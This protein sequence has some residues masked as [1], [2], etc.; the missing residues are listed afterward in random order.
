M[1]LQPGTSS[2]AGIAVAEIPHNLPR[3]NTSFVGREHALEECVRLLQT[4]RLL[5]LTG[6]GGSGK[7]RLALRLAEQLLPQYPNGVWFVDLAPLTDGDR[8]PNVVASALGVSEEAGRP[9]RETLVRH[10]AARRALIVLDNCEHVIGECAS[11]AAALLEAADG[12]WIVATSREMLGIHGE[13]T[14]MT[15]SL[16]LARGA[17]EDP[18]RARDSEAVRLFA[19]RARLTHSAFTLDD[20]TAPVV[21]DICQRLDGIPLAIE[22]AA[23][24]V[25]MLSV[26][27]IRAR[28]HDRFRLLAGNRAAA[29]PRHQT[30]RAAMQWSYEHLGEE[31]QRLL[32]GLSIFVGGWT[33]DAA[34]GVCAEGRDEFEVLDLL[35]GLVNK[36]LVLAEQPG[37]DNARY[38][39]LETVREYAQDLQIER[40]ER[41]A[42]RLGHAQ[43]FLTWV[44]HAGRQVTGAEQAQWLDR[45][46]REAGNLRAALDGF[47]S[48][49]HLSEAARVA[50]SMQWLWVIRGY[51]REGRARLEAIAQRA[52]ELE[53]T[54]M[55]AN[56]IQGAGNMCYRLDDFD[57][58]RAHYQRAL[59]MR[60]R[61]GDRAGMAG[62]LGALGNVMQYQGQFAEALQLFSRSIAINRETGNKVWEGANLTCLG[63]CSRAIGDLAASRQY[64]DQALALNREIGHRNGECFSL[65]GLGCVLLQTGDHAGA[66]AAFEQA[67]SIAREIGNDHEQG[68]TLFNMA[69]LDMAIGDLAAARARFC[70]AIRRMRPL[71]SHFEIAGCLHRL[72]S[73]LHTQGDAPR[74]IRLWAFVEAYRSTFGARVDADFVPATEQIAAA[75]EALG[76]ATFEQ[77]WAEGS[78]LTLDQAIDAALSAEE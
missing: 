40:G 29:L 77:S 48:G 31:E 46:D 53:P 45:M 23:A 65:D 51:M 63:N 69:R 15:P 14:Y 52:S 49:D 30:L 3:Q 24:R 12:I 55:L 35:T 67:L 6:V 41:D 59:E 76:A 4:A 9:L 66:R 32:R 17:M 72:A 73:V 8:V 68:I 43:W 11:L 25:R 5:T 61:I 75:R 20:D 36:S 42:A 10:L 7:T 33:L 26:T 34:V 44:E 18:S 54:S 62:S 57:A 56:V 47:E 2:Y 22:L 70:E 78:Q 1:S 38:R 60:E 50:G 13:Q 19:D 16:S 37:E 28:L 21:A 71:D 64:L 74:A 27:Q 58:A 39:F